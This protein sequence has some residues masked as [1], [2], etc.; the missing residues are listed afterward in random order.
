M[1]NS[2]FDTVVAM[3]GGVDSTVA[4]YLSQRQG[5]RVIGVNLQMLPDQEKDETL[6]KACAEMGIPLI[7]R[8]CVEPFSRRVLEVCAAEYAAGRTPNPCCECNVALKFR[9]IFAAAD[10]LGIKRVVTGHYVQLQ[11]TEGHCCIAGAADQVKDQSYFLYRLSQEE[12]QRL[13]LPLG[14]FT[15]SEVRRQAAAAG[16]HCAVRPD[17]QDACFQIP[18]E[19]CGDTL[20]R[21]C[22]MRGRGGRFRYQGKVVGRH[23]GIHRFTIGQRQGLGVALGVPA[24]IK[25]ID[26]ASGDIELC[27]DQNELLCQEFTVSRCV[28]QSIPVPETAMECMVKVRYR[29]RGVRAV[30]IPG[31]DSESGRVE[32]LEPVRAVTPG[33]AAVFYGDGVLLGGGVISR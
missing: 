15:K 25:S 28:W 26:A 5:F 18:G 2:E 20:L 31:A 32:I 3:S 33:Q 27:T 22:G 17:S 10:E 9:E 11:Q 29:T 24:Y 19:C 7:Y 8:D 4:A 14:A 23:A 30:F 21:L 12:L 1:K 13:Y 6:I 16:L